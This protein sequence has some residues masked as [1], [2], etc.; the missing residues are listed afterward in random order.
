M[1]R[2]K[3]YGFYSDPD[4]VRRVVQ[5]VAVMRSSAP[6]EPVRGLPT[7]GYAEDQPSAQALEQFDRALGDAPMLGAD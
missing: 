5:A 1:S 7:S 6:R 3:P 2:A 4:A